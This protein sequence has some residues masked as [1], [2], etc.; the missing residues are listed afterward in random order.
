M[1]SRHTICQIA[2]PNCRQQA[3]N[4]VTYALQSPPIAKRPRS[5]RMKSAKCTAC[6]ED[7]MMELKCFR[8]VFGYSRLVLYANTQNETLN[9]NPRL[10]CIH[11]NANALSAKAS[12]RSGSTSG[13]A[14]VQALPL[15]TE[16]YVV[17]FCT[18]LNLNFPC[19]RCVG[20]SRNAE[21]NAENFMCKSCKRCDCVRRFAIIG[22]AGSRLHIT[23]LTQ[24]LL[25]LLASV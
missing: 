4:N 14:S 6:A 8:Q 23:A 2:L 3:P 11:P 21:E 9:P 25:W 18:F 10:R 24:R 15:Q 12:A 19:F 16:R 7:L 22:H 13:A 20:L 5:Q 17:V 1:P